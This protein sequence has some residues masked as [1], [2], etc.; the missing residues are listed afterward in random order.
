MDDYLQRVRL[1]AY[2]IWEKQGRPEGLAVDHWLEAEQQVANEPDAAGLQ[3]GRDCDKGV[4]EFEKS[5]RVERAAKEA[6]EAL[7]GPE[8]ADLEQAQENARRRGGG[9]DAS[10]RR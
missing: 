6:R 1:R 2:L 3:A 9:N 4:Q 10:G 7:D 5:G 8:R